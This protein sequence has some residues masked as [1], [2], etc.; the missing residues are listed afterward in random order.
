MYSLLAFHVNFHHCACYECPIISSFRKPFLIHDE[1][2]FSVYWENFLLVRHCWKNLFQ[3][4]AWPW[5]VFGSEY[6]FLTKK[7]FNNSG[8][9]EEKIFAAWNCECY[10]D[11]S[12][13][14]QN[15]VIYQK[16]IVSFYIIR[17]T[18][19]S[20]FFVFFIDEF[21]FFCFIFIWA[22]PIT[23]ENRYKTSTDRKFTVFL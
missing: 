22:K 19:P 3:N 20:I 8:P 18:I 4:L 10:F 14:Q 7:F 13:H 15:S 2:Y 17:L 6:F 1:K 12:Q 11:N 16:N 23:Y 21:S 5:P 9:I